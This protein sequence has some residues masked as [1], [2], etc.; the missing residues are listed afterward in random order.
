MKGNGEDAVNSNVKKTVLV[1]TSADY[2]VN[3]ADYWGDRYNSDYIDVEMAERFEIYA[4]MKEWQ[5]ASNERGW[6]WNEEV[7]R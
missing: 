2:L 6:I 7:G 1:E 3:P 4:T 5:Y